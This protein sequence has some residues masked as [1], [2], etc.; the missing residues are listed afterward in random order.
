MSKSRIHYD[1]KTRDYARYQGKIMMD[2]EENVEL[3]K[4]DG[5]IWFV[6]TRKDKRL[7]T[8]EQKITS[9]TDI[10]RLDELLEYLKKKKPLGRVPEQ[11]PR[12]QDY[13]D[14]EFRN[15]ESAWAKS[16]SILD[17]TLTQKAQ[18]FLDSQSGG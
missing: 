17:S 11:K 1:P 13:T 10:W 18:A 15:L 2:S 5:Y 6:V 16:L 12:K 7:E 14:P 4:L 9:S 8:I 3:L